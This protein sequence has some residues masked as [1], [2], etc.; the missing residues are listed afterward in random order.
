MLSC[1]LRFASEGAKNLQIAMDAAEAY[2]GLEQY[3]K[4]SDI[5]LLDEKS[6]LVY[7]SEYYTGYPERNK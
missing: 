2:F 5:P 1:C 4:P 7:V 3:L 6:M